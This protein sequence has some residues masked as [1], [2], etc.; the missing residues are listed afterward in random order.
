ML[1]LPR[2]RF[3]GPR[4][5]ALLVLL[6]I[7]DL[8]GLAVVAQAQGDADIHD[9]TSSV[10]YPCALAIDSSGNRYGIAEGGG[11]HG[12]GAI[13]EQTTSGSFAILHSFGSGQTVPY[14]GDVTGLDGYY[15]YGT[16]G[17][18]A[19]DSH[20]N[21]Y[22]D[23]PN[24]GNDLEGVIW[25]ITSTG[26][27]EVLHS[28]GGTATL[29]NGATGTDGT[30]V[31]G[32]L[33][34]DGSGNLF[35]ST[36]S[37]GANHHGL[38]WKISTSGSYTDLF[39]FG[40]SSGA[41]QGVTV[42]ASGD[43]YGTTYS[44]GTNLEGVVWEI[45]EGGAYTVLHNF[46]GQQDGQSDGMSPS[47][48]V[49]L[50]GSGDIFGTTTY[51]GSYG[52]GTA[53]EITGLGTYTILHNF[54]GTAETPSGET[55]ADGQDL[56][57]GVSF[58]SSGNLYG[59]AQAGGASGDGVVWE[60]TKF[61]TYVDL[62]D[63]SAKPFSAVGFDS[64]GNLFGVTQNGGANSYG[65]EWE[66]SGVNGVSLSP[67]SV[68]A[69]TA[70][71]GT[72]TIPFSA[73]SGGWLVSLSSGNP[74]YIGV[75]TS[76]TIPAGQTSATFPVTTKDY[77]GSYE[78]FVTAD[79]GYV[80]QQARI[81]VAPLRVS[82]LTVSPSPVL[83]GNSATGLLTITGVAPTGGWTVNLSSNTS[84]VSLPSSVT[85]PAGSTSTTFTLTPSDYYA[86]FTATIKASD[87][88]SS[89]T[90][91][92]KVSSTFLSSVSASPNPVSAGGSCTGTVTISQAAPSGGWTVNLISSTSHVTVPSSVV[93]PAGST[94]T[95]FTITPGDYYG[96]YTASI[97]ATDTVSSKSTTLTVQ[98]IYLSSVS[99]SPNP[100][101]AGGT[102]SGTVTISRA[103]PSGGWTVNLSSSTSYVTVPASVVIPAGS[104]TTTFTITAAEYYG[105]Y[106]ATI[107][108]TDSVSSKSTTLTVDSTTVASVSL[109]P[110]EV[111]NGTSSLGTVTLSGPAPASGLTVHLTSSAPGYASVPT[112]L[113]FAPGASQANFTVS[114]GLQTVKFNY[115]ITISAS[116]EGPGKSTTLTLTP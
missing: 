64:S 86:N 49:T 73:P 34:I 19:V 57:Y 54:G 101:S 2:L 104:T 103:A 102:C 53:W 9:F 59:T 13:W 61:G 27:Y 93:I 116:I 3:L 56:F 52:Y 16:T 5:R 18:L 105:N 100:M 12:D 47:A 32:C 65:M 96:N 38:V 42:D 95:T 92:M 114:T 58:D 77:S 20:G 8:V 91:P 78:G 33:A 87:S 63:F 75:P 67:N 76:V 31:Y 21:L 69:L 25:E 80:L 17:N 89:I 55:V 51:G 88:V 62:H 15:G 74:S 84:H 82:S 113:T 112:T 46:G 79:D 28:F 30:A 11:L 111:A 10:S 43:L 115:T 107:K 98:T 106:T 85:I 60:L 39:D 66:I 4:L 94:S 45:P 44:G 7:L 90:A 41:S 70:A 40:A 108:A 24:G 6:A 71:T 14:A 68:I 26:S 37:G 50:D 36:K 83:F 23:A 1:I 97:K 29:S 22:G 110:S 72:V 48:G 35:G 99:A 81:V 109:S